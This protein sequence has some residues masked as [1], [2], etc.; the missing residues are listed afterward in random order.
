M[1]EIESAEC[2]AKR[3]RDE[4][5]TMHEVAGRAGDNTLV[6][7]IVDAGRPE[8]CVACGNQTLHSL[9]QEIAR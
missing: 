3:A 9:G 7:D 8:R 2:L 6:A 1:R 4:R 5:E